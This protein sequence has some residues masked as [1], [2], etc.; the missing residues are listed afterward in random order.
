MSVL[1]FGEPSDLGEVPYTSYRPWLLEKLYCRVCAYCLVHNPVVIHIDHYEPR[2]YAPHRV[3]DPKNLLLACS[4]CNGRGGKGDYHPLYQSRTRLPQDS[5]GHHVLDVRRD[6]LGRMY[7]VLRSGRLRARPGAT[8]HRAIWNIALLK[9]DLTSYEVVRSEYLDT[10]DAAEQLVRE[11]E[12]SDEANSGSRERILDTLV[13]YLARRRLFF[14]VFD[15]EISKGLT[16][17]LAAVE[18]D[19]L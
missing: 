11:I 12:E 4:A 2:G 16:A 15:I 3:D 6:D 5:T 18:K 10:L 1:D 9:L 17:R 13:R 19:P 14:D 7:E 8:E